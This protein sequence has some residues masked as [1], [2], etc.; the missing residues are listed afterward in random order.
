VLEGF[1]AGI[2]LGAAL[3][4]AIFVTIGLM[5]KRALVLGLLMPAFRPA[6]QPGAQWFYL[7]RFAY[8]GDSK[9]AIARALLLHPFSS[10]WAAS[11]PRKLL[12]LFLLGLPFAFLP[13][14]RGRALAYS[15]AVV[16]FVAARYLSARWPECFF[17]FHYLVPV[18]PVLAYAALSASA[19]QEN[20]STTPG[21]VSARLRLAPLCVALAGLVGIAWR[22]DPEPLL[23]R[24]NQVAL[25]EAIALV[26]SDAPVC[27]E[28]WFGAHLAARRDIDFCVLWEFEREQYRYYGWPDA[29]SANYQLYDLAEPRPYMPGLAARAKDLRV[30]GAEVL[31]EREGVLLLRVSDEV[32]RRAPPFVSVQEETS[33]LLIRK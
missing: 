15:L 18:V 4:C 12:T 14:T 31:Y 8:L 28:N 27:V 32:L 25:A 9:A 22:L 16:P 7:G 19:A 11:D 3:Y 23:P 5:S 20:S 17:A 10:L 24:P 21:P 13:F 29:S 33:P 1:T 2:A 30:A 26:P 6:P